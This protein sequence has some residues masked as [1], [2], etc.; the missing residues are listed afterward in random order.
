MDGQWSLG[1]RRPVSVRAAVADW[2]VERS[3]HDYS[4]EDSFNLTIPAPALVH[5]L[6]LRLA[7]G[8]SLAYASAD[9]NVLFKD[10]SAEEPGFSA[11]VV[12][13]DAMCAFLD[14][15]GLEIVW[16]LTGEKSAHGGRRHGNAW[17]GMLE[18]WG[19]YRLKNGAV[20]GSLNFRRQDASPEQLTELLAG[21]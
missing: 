11:A 21:P 19:L 7:E 17:G 8:R 10:P 20:Q 5:G 2:Y 4:V 13:R 16:T 6:K 14:A 3:G 12:D 18:W 15:E 9:G 1:Q